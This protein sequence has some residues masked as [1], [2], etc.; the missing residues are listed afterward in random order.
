MTQKP[1]RLISLDALRGFT[2]AGMILVNVPGTWEHIYWP[3]KHAEF[4]GLTLADLVFPFFLFIVG[5]SIVLALK[6]R[7]EGGVS[8]IELLQKIIKRTLVI[9]V[10]GVFLNWMS[11]GF[12]FP[13]RI[14]GVL[15]RIAWCYMLGSLLFI[16]TSKKLQII[17]SGLIL[18]AYWLLSVFIPV[19]GNSVP[20]LSFDVSWTA[21]VDLQIL[22]G[23]MYFGQW[24]PEGILS[25]FPALVNTLLG[26]I[27]TSILLSIP[28]N[29]R[30]VRVLIIFGLSILVLGLLI[31]FSFPINKN[32]WSSSYVLVTSGIASLL[33]GILI[34]LVDIKNYDTWTKPGVIFG[35]NA[36]SAYILHYL[37]IYPFT[38]IKMNGVC[39]KDFIVET[40]GHFM[41]M[42]LSSLIWAIFFVCVNFL[43]VWWMYKKKIFVKI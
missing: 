39:F 41:P 22:P 5:A 25:T 20:I 37:L 33:W 8:K 7:V 35:A 19:P 10:L 43:P 14:A 38:L 6:K 30:K 17:I 32:I 3:F 18:I 24:D 1:K 29:I 27:V 23:K 4:N 12:T 2:V 28:E 13:I 15:Q 16:Y 42:E 21:W 34:Y 11:S 40:F 36:L 31:S 9:F 26:I